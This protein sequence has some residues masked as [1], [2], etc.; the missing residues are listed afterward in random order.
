[1]S[2]VVDMMCIEAAP[3]GE[4]VPNTGFFES[5]AATNIIIIII[6]GLADA[7]SAQYSV[8]DRITFL[9]RTQSAPKLS[10]EYYKGL[11]IGKVYTGVSRPLRP[12]GKTI[13]SI[14]R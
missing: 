5:F 14:D 9:V 3:E 10:I 11:T 12:D 8:P 6:F 7:M 4:G 1:M 2:N 13:P